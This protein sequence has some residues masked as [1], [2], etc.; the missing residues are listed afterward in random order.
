MFASST[1]ESLGKNTA[2]TFCSSD[3]GKEAKVCRKWGA[4]WLCFSGRQAEHDYVYLYSPMGF[5]STR[6]RI[7]KRKMRKKMEIEKRAS[8]IRLLR[9]WS[10]WTRR[11]CK[12]GKG[13]TSLNQNFQCYTLMSGRAFV[14]GSPV[15]QCEYK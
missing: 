6:L 15:T 12:R 11:V 2:N 3:A 1:E 4:Y 7:A 13:H 9:L 14:T 8:T 10:A 5:V